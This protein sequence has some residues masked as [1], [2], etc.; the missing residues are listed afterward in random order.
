MTKIKYRHILFRN[1]VRCDKMILKKKNKGKM[2]TGFAI[3]IMSGTKR[4]G[5]GAEWDH[6]PD[7]SYCQ[8][9]NFCVNCLTH[10]NTCGREGGRKSAREE[11]KK[12]GSH[13]WTNDDQGLWMIQFT[14]LIS[15]KKLLG[16]WGG[17]VS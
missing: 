7:R 4:W 5:E 16:Y 12:G 17:S 11:G 9:L 8:G 14:H 2:N 13:L 6:R 1:I 3:V 10:L 15:I